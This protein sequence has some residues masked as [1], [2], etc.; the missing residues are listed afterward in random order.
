M[1]QVTARRTVAG[2]VAISVMT[3]PKV[4]FLTAF[5]TCPLCATFPPEPRGQR[6]LPCVHF[7]SCISLGQ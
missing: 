5:S 7:K 1:G 2:T 6:E 4:A 3:T